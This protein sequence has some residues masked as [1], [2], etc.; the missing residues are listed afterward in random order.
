[1]LY[2]LKFR[3]RLKERI[4]GG[5]KLIA[6]GK[7]PPRGMSSDTPVGESWEISGLQGDVSVIANGFL[8]SNNLQEAIEVYMGELIGDAV[9]DKYGLE[10]PLLVK[11]IEAHEKLSVQV[12]PDEELAIERHGARGKTEMWYVIDAA[13]GAYLY[14][15][16]N[17]AVSRSE[18]L[19]AVAD[20]SVESLLKRYEVSAG[21]AFY[22]PAGTVHAVGEG[23]LFA[24]I[25]QTSDITYRIDD[26]GRVDADGNHRQLHIEESADAINYEYAGGYDITGRANPNSHIEL[27]SSPYFTTELLSVDGVMERDYS[28]LDSFV[29]YIC[30]AGECRVTTDSGTENLKAFE[31]L[32]LPAIDD[33]VKIEGRATLLEVFIK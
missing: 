8:K 14:I 23:V 27:A 19:K 15:G 4:W 10:F 5:N 31:T 30:T 16:F 11:F 18:Y 33:E 24:E 28:S 21:D 25:Q 17:R 9:Y 29:I 6:S 22:I 3:P 7:K 1:M 12:H 2:P 32:M 26:W 20:G 13:P